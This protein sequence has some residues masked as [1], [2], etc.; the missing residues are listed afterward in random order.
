MLRAAALL[1]VLAAC[2]APA[3][4]TTP[5]QRASGSVEP[6]PSATPPNPTPAV[7]ESAWE[8]LDDAPFARLE[9][10]VTAHQGRIWLAGGLSPLNEALADVAIFDPATGEWSTGPSLP[11]GIHHGTLVSDGSRLLLVGG[12][13][14]RSPSRP[15]S[16]VLVLDETAGVW[17]EGPELPDARGAGAA[18]FDG[19]RV[20]FAG[21]VGTSGES[22]ADVFALAGDSW[23]R[24]GAMAQARNHLAAVSD[25]E[26]HVWLLGGR[27]SGVTNNLADV[28]L[29]AGATIEQLEPLPTARSGV[30]GFYAPGIG[31]CLT[32]GEGPD[33]AFTTVECIDAEGTV[34][35]LPGLNEA[36]HGHGAAVVDGVA[37][38]LLGGPEPRLSASSVVESFVLE[39]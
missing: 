1:L 5:P 39:P 23:E 26:G 22:A 24:I 37:Y 36:H 18:T 17:R 7:A 21:G 14:G 13:I 2:A 28:D 29:V 15:I 8:V 19:S 12:F 31:A 4:T 34:T 27:V 35:T 11:T 30:G 32:G 16:F 9:M 33:L 20:V 10:A 6:D 38:V 3:P 25:G